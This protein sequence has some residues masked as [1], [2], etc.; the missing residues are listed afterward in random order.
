MS[1]QDTGVSLSDDG[2]PTHR[3]AYEL[4][5]IGF[6]IGST[7]ILHGVDLDIH[8]GEVLAIVGPNGAGKSTLL[9]LLTGEKKPTTGRVALHDVQVHNWQTRDLARTRSVLLQ[10][11]HVAFAFTVQQVVEMG[12]APW[13]GTERAD[14]DEVKIAEAID[15]ADIHPLVGR[16]YPSLSGGEKARTSLARVL[17][18]DTAIVLLDEPTAALDLRHQEDVLVLARELADAGRAVVVVLHDL[19]LAAAYSD[20]V[21]II[22]DGTVAAYGTPEEVFTAERIHAVYDVEVTLLTDPDLGRPIIL[23][24]RSRGSR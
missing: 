17:A 15:R 4:R 13:L 18:Q 7:T 5:G 6:E 3:T 1:D 2:T 12:R 20:S 16:R 23:P 24:K 10:S 8:Y 14:D 21:A 11:N 9:S 22:D 19:S